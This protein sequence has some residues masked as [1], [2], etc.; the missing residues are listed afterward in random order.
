MEA[1]R[2]QSDTFT[3][4]DPSSHASNRQVGTKSKL[5]DDDDDGTDWEQA[6]VAGILPYQGDLSTPRNVF[7][8]CFPDA[9]SFRFL[10]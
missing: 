4:N 2:K 8:L 3:E 7:T 5:E 10:S 6:P 9:V 1:S